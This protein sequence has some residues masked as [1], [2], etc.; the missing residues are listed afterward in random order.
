MY[1]KKIQEDTRGIFKRIHLRIH[2]ELLN[3]ELKHVYTYLQE[4]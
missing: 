3:M 4:N 2:E 1:T